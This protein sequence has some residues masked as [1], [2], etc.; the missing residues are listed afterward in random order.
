MGESFLFIEKLEKGENEV[1]RVSLE[2]Y[3]DLG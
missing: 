2:R 1:G 3:G